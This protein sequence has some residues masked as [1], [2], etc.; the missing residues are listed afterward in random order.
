MCARISCSV[1]SPLPMTRHDGSG[2]GVENISLAPFPVLD[3]PSKAGRPEIQEI[4]AAGAPFDDR[5][6]AAGTPSSS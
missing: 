5:L 3:I 4:I 1:L 6:A 2:A